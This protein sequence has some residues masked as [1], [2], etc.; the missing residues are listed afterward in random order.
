MPYAAK[1]FAAWNSSEHSWVI[2]EVVSYDAK[3]K[4]YTCT[5]T[6]PEPQTQSRIPDNEENIYACQPEVMEEDVNDL[7]EL[8]ELHESTLLF[9]LKRRYLKDV[10]Y[11]N[12][13]PIVVAL[14]PFNYNIP[15]Y[16]DS[17][18]PDYLSE[19]VVIERNLPHSWAVAHNTYWELR[20]NSQDQTILISG[21]SGAGKTEGAKIVVKYLGAISTLKGTAE[22]KE[23]CNNVNKKIIAAS[24]IL[25][26]FGNAKTVRNDN[27]SRFGKFMKLQFDKDGFLLGANAIKYLLEKSRIVTASKEERVYHSF[28][29]LVQG[30][31][32]AKYGLKDAGVY[33]SL[34]AGECITIPKVDDAQDH[35]ICKAAMTEVGISADQQ[36]AIWRCVAGILSIQN[37]D[38]GERE[39]KSMKAAFVDSVY[40]PVL[41]H[42]CTLWGI[43]T[44]EM[45]KELTSTTTVTRGEVVVKPLDRM[46]AMDCR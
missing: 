6:D 39:D 40:T 17:K 5:S 7:L 1:T 26:S 44:P 12:I 34:T 4:S 2:G 15:N 21:E 8:T 19:G 31:D 46:K 43:V 28:Y 14:N 25:E 37:V 18:M 16:M 13:G 24:P 30:S 27:S 38:F 32:K 23:A 33:K 41:D 45:E 35:T 22:Q 20:E 36:D 3:S 9:C 10:V 42:A 11:T 29:Q